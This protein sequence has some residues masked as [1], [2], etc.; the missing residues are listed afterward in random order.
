MGISIDDRIGGLKARPNE[1]ESMF[2]KTYTLRLPDN[3]DPGAYPIDVRATYDFDRKIT[4]E[5]ATLNVN[6]C[7]TA[8]TTNT[9]TQTTT[10]PQEDNNGVVLIMPK[11]TDTT[12]NNNPS[13]F[14][15]IIL[16]KEGLL[17][18][19]AFAIGIIIAEIAIVVI[20]VI[21]VVGLFRR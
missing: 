6:K 20:G 17:S 9:Q 4:E 16:T 18:S 13:I 2:S 15:G 7:T 8:T 14:P 11:T 19:D 1:P 12:A 21:L 5:T 3:I 10:T